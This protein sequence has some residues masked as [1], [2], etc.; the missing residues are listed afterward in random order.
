MFRPGMG[1]GPGHPAS[2]S[3]FAACGLVRSYLEQLESIEAK[4]QE[5]V[6]APGI[7]NI[8]SDFTGIFEQSER[9]ALDSAAG[10]SRTLVSPQP[11][12]RFDPFFS[13]L[14]PTFEPQQQALLFSRSQRLTALSPSYTFRLVSTANAEC[15]PR[16]SKK[17]RRSSWVVL[18]TT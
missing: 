9:S 1:T 2:R 11:R 14:P 13:F 18:V 8:L 7:G 15:L 10:G 3:K 16:R 12:L 4:T 17:R 5:L 6:R